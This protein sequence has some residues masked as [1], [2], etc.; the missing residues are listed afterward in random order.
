MKKYISLWLSVILLVGMLSGCL[1]SGNSNLASQ[2]TTTLPTTAPTQPKTQPT[3]VP[4]QPTTV[5]TQP[6]D[7]TEELEAQAGAK[8]ETGNAAY[9]KNVKWPKIIK[10]KEELEGLL[11]SDFGKMLH[12]ETISY[13][14]DRYDDAFFEEYSLVLLGMILVP[15]YVRT[16]FCVESCAK[17]TDL[18]YYLIE[19]SSA[20]TYMGSHLFDRYSVFF[21]EVKDDIPVDAIIYFELLGD[22][23]ANKIIV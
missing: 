2:P 14:T 20:G 16:W 11:N 15:H 4:T 6:E 8:P 3:T 5:P 22:L 10:S 21:I 17:N 9:M 1:S 19:L 7:T 18:G 12:T 13:V 23:A